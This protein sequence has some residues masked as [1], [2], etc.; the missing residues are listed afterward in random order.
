MTTEYMTD[1]EVSRIPG[2][3]GCA[4]QTVQDRRQDRCRIA[5]IDMR[6]CCRACVFQEVCWSKQELEILPCGEEQ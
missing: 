6:T 4:H 2:V 5:P 1:Y 3:R